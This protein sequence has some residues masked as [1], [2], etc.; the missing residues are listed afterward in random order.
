ME[1]ILKL[2]LFSEEFA[3][4]DFAIKQHGGTINSHMLSLFSMAF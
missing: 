3:Q 4:R 1:I 2:T